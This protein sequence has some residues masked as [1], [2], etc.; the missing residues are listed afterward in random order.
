MA[1]KPELLIIRKALN[2]AFN[3][4]LAADEESEHPITKATLDEIEKGL[5]A[6]N[7]LEKELIRGH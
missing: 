5:E 3:T 6:L 7:K 2:R 1:T 4:V